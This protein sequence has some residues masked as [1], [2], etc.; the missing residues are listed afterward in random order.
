M[1]SANVSEYLDP[2]STI[3]ESPSRSMLYVLTR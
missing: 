2:S 1:W 3:S